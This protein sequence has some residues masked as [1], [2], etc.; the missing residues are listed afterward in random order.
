MAHFV[1]DPNVQCV[2][3]L[4][5]N[6]KRDADKQVKHKK[7]LISSYR[8]PHCGFWH[9]GGLKPATNSRREYRDYMKKKVIRKLPEKAKGDVEIET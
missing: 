2:G 6:S 8:C 9:V 7:G 1:S 3:K 5:H 4:G